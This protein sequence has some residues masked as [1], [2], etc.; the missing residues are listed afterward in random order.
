MEKEINDIKEIEKNSN[1]NR[2]VMGILFIIT[3]I[4]QM[5]REDT[6][7]ILF[8]I[9]SVLFAINVRYWDLK[10]HILKNTINQK[11]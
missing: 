11:R 7:A 10:K 8:C 4:C 3:V 2:N 5:F 6:Y 9:L 1:K